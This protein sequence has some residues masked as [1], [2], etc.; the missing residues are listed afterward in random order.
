MFAA[1]DGTVI[2]A[3]D[4]EFDMSTGSNGK[5]PA[6]FAL[7]GEEPVSTEARIRDEM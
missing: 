2:D 5:N 3:Y 7:V 1:L 6:N 4:A